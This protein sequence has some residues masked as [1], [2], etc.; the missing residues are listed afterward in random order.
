[1]HYLDNAAT[2][3]AS[4][5]AVLRAVTVMRENF[6]NPS[7]LHAMGKIALQE[8]NSARASVAAAIGAQPGSIEF[9][10]CGS[11]ANNQALVSASY[12]NRHVGKH[13][14]TSAVEHPSVL[15]AL[16]QLKAG[17]AE[18]TYL[19]PGPDGAVR[20]ED[21]A[22]ALR[23]DTALV[24]L[25]LVNNETGAVNPIRAV[26][27]LL[28][29]RKHPA[30]LHTDAV[31][32]LF[33]VPIDVKTLG[34]DYMSLSGHKIHAPKGVG[35][36]YIRAG[37]RILP[38]IFGGGQENGARSGTENLASIAAFGVAA[39]EGKEKF[40]ENAAR[41]VELRSYLEERI[42]S[43]PFPCEINYKG[44]AH[45]ASVCLPGCR[46]EV[47]LRILS[48]RGIFVSAGSA[49][50]KGRRSHVLTACGLAPEKIDCTIRVSFS[51]YNDKSDI[52]ALLAGL[53]DAYARFHRK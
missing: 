32:G 20:I 14:L 42:T 47:V 28:D 13:I 48:D 30:L 17:G 51:D 40:S 27:A 25:M 50:A 9:V 36:L 24:T 34:V 38:L 37:R 5:D 21:V 23:D 52:D 26:R 53:G 7:S 3:Q 39:K 12:V 10:S 45:I 46:S 6:G 33:K 29:E 1:M 2:T 31:Q 8:L 4:A 43:A 16:K 35:A 11:E 18:I 15:E 22:A 19:N 49:C 41:A 44:V